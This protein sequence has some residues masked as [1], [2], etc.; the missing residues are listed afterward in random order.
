[1]SRTWKHVALALAIAAAGCD[2]AGRDDGAPAVRSANEDGRL[3]AVDEL[4][5]PYDLHDGPGGVLGVYLDGELVYAR[6]FGLANLEYGIPNTPSTVFRVGSVSKQFAAMAIAILARRGELQLDDDIR[7]YLPEIPLYPEGV[8]TVRHLVHHTSGLRD[9]NELAGFAGYRSD[10]LATTAATFELLARQRGLNFPPGDQF[11]YSNSGYFLIAVLVERVTGKT[12]AEFA[13]SEIFEPLGMRSSLFKDDHGAVVPERAYGYV[14]GRDTDGWRLYMSQRDFVG[15]GGVFTTAQDMLQWFVHLEHGDPELM[16]Q[17]SQRGVL[18]NGDELDY[19]FGLTFD[20]DR[21]LRRVHHSGGFAA[22]TAHTVRYPEQR[23]AVFTAVNGGNANAVR[24][25]LEIAD[26]YLRPL[27]PELAPL[28][29]PTSSS[30]AQA[31]PVAAVQLTTRDLGGYAGTYDGGEVNAT[32]EVVRTDEGLEL[33]IPGRDPVQLQAVG[34]GV[35]ASSRL[36]VTFERSPA[37]PVTG[38]TL[39]GRRA[40]GLVFERV[41]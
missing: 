33:T 39:D 5:T 40:R 4:V 32:Y 16:E 37:G 8:V 20:D 6:G 28:A 11:L 19:A 23:L 1:M 21:G 29:S 17:M 3:V 12:M 35:F 10:Q 41:D 34:S 36:R 22:F 31:E 2:P 25:A 9:Y 18:N 7:K 30:T 15:A 14:R 26:V 38:F 27:V 24:L 13:R